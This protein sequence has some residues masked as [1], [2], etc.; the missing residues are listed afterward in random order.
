[1]GSFTALIVISSDDILNVL[2]ADDALVGYGTELHDV[3]TERISKTFGGI[4]AHAAL[5]IVHP[6]C[7]KGFR[8]CGHVF[9]ANALRFVRSQPPNSLLRLLTHTGQ[10][11]PNFPISLY[12]LDVGGGYRFSGDSSVF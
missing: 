8:E 5:V 3:L 6:G 4:K 2:R 9:A 1:M 7:I 11:W 12:P 10:N